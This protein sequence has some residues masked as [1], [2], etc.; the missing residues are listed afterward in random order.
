[1]F[2]GAVGIGSEHPISVQGMTKAPADDVRATV[3]QARELQQLGCQIL[4]VAVPRKKDLRLLARVREAV[5]IALEA[6]VHF[7]VQIALEAIGVGVDAV[8]INPGNMDS[9]A[10]WRRLARQLVKTG[11]AVRV[12]SNSGS[13]PADAARYCSRFDWPEEDHAC[14]LAAT[15]LNCA[16]RLESMGVGDIIISAK[17]S[18][19][20]ATVEAYRRLASACD[21]PL[22]VG[23]TASGTLVPGL[24]KSATALGLLLADGIGDTIRISLSGPPHLEIKAAWEVLYALGLAS[25]SLP[26][27]VA[28]PTCGRCE[29]DVVAIAQ[30][31]ERRIGSLPH[32]LRVAVMGCVVN[33]PG[34]AKD[35]DIGIAG[36]RG[37]GFL[38]REGKKVSGKIPQHGLVEALVKAVRQL[39]A[40]GEGK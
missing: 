14:Q 35:C 19:V 29:I 30:E 21:Y 16:K 40:G 6:D 34:E 31:V 11:T 3:R 2:Y 4:R 38:F 39:I 8:R 22:H 36:G 1:V 10:D 23:V 24:V 25:R 5:D 12:G 20:M 26:E 37:F 28:C 15:A 32:P 9:V 17:S 33:G 27:V 13:L 7:S 18:H